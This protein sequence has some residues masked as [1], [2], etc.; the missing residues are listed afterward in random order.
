[1]PYLPSSLVIEARTL[2][3]PNS[4]RPGKTAQTASR[5]ESS[6]SPSHAPAASQRWQYLRHTW[7]TSKPSWGRTM[8]H[9]RYTNSEPQLLGY[10][11][12][13]RLCARRGT[14]RVSGIPI[15]EVSGHQHAALL[16]A[17][18]EDVGRELRIALGQGGFVPAIPGAF[19]EQCQL[20]GFC[21]LPED[22]VR[23]VRRETTVP[24]HF[25]R[26]C[27]CRRAIGV[28]AR[29]LIGHLAR[30]CRLRLT[31]DQSRYQQ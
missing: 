17:G 24:A 20:L 22:E 26:S 9:S 21:P 11:Q 15:V 4:S 16:A 14:R 8:S 13:D 12:A 19:T 1:M 31:R 5:G 23:G 29:R 10:D 27:D 28:T 30:G 2:E 25:L 3:R 6:L 7:R 18:L